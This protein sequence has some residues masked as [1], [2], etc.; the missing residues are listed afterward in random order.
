M[1]NTVSTMTVKKYFDVIHPAV[2]HAF[3]QADAMDKIKNGEEFFGINQ[4]IVKEN[5][6]VVD[7]YC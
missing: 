5:T 7:F 1:E 6:H 3:Q 2:E 4:P